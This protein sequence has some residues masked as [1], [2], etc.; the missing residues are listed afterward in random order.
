M[1]AGVARR[2]QRGLAVVEFAMVLPILVVLVFGII[3]L[4]RAV[5][6]HQVLINVSREA[7][8]LASRGTALSDAMAAVMTSAQPLD[9]PGAGYVILTEVVRDANGHARIRAQAASGS[10]SRPSRVGTG[11][12]SAAALP[13][14]T[15]LV[16][17][18]GLS[19]FVAEVFYDSAP[20]TP[21][22][23]L[24]GMTMTDVFYDIAF[25]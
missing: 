16:P 19:L 14:T 3:D 9:L 13:A 11:V 12:G 2:A 18:P 25:F 6:T 23:P 20:I 1:N 10:R 17:P 21:I 4:G 5:L 8:N 15:P 7:A 22:G 24:V